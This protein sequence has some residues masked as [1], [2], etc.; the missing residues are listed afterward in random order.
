VAG[1]KRVLCA[2]KFVE[3]A[4]IEPL[5]DL[6]ARSTEIVWLEDVRAVDRPA[7]PPAGGRGGRPAPAVPHQGRAGRA[8]R[9]P[10]HQRQLRDA[11]GRGADPRQPDRQRGADRPHID[12]DPDWVWFNPL[13]T[14][15]CFGL[16][17][18]VLLP[19]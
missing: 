7:R 5:T 2:H 12:L 13:P 19:C 15:H 16:T 18:G 14:F 3:Q 8:G 6:L 17:A 11:E 9:H 4:K 10:V 1:V